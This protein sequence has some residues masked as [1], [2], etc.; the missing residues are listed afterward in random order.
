MAGTKLVPEKIT[1]PFQLMAAWFSMLILLVSVLLTGAVNITRPD[2]AA[3]YLVIFSSVVVVA[4]LS[5]VTLMLTVFR[6]HLQEGKE[7]AQ[8]LKDTNTYSPGLIVKERTTVRRSRRTSTASATLATRIEID[9]NFDVLVNAACP[10][11]ME[12]L[13]V[14]RRSLF[15]AEGYRSPGEGDN[16]REDPTESAAIWIGSRVQGAAAVE[17][18]KLAVTAWPHLKYMHLS[19][20]DLDPPDEIHDQVFFGGA[21]ST[22]ER[23]GLRA[24]SFEEIRDLPSNITDVDFHKAIRGKYS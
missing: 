22:A 8:W 24:W 3:G 1:S 12:V 7:Y 4:V 23:F 6:P 21:T 2:W 18:I 17:A 14:L 9:R 10:K 20:D 15:S 16:H 13:E 5:C 11:S 19:S